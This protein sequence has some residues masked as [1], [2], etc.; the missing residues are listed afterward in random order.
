PDRFRHVLPDQVPTRNSEP[1]KVVVPKVV[2]FFGLESPS[3]QAA[4]QGH[5]EP[6]HQPAVQ[7]WFLR[8]AVTEGRQPRDT[9]M[10]RKQLVKYRR[11]APTH[12]H[13]THWPDLICHR[14][15]LLP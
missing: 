14:S 2:W 15:A 7:T 5:G 9:R 13:D 10:P 4:D 8:V 11:A 12:A 3:K 1:R 6:P